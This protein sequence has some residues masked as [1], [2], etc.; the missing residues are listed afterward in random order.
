[1]TDTSPNSWLL[2]AESFCT[3]SFV[4]WCYHWQWIVVSCSQ[5]NKLIWHEKVRIKKSMTATICILV[6]C[7]FYD[8]NIICLNISPCF[9]EFIHIATFYMNRENGETSSL[10]FSV[11]TKWCISP[12]VFMMLLNLHFIFPALKPPSSSLPLVASRHPVGLLPP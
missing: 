2:C 5:N 8:E 1:M 7:W 6:Q 3:T 12:L 11:G 4:V 10:S 9:L